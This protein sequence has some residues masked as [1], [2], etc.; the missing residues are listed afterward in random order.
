MVNLLLFPKKSVL[1]LLD[2]THN[3]NILLYKDISI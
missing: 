2:Y 3:K 1:L